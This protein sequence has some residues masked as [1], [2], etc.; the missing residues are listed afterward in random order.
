MSAPFD[1]T[2]CGACCIEAGEVEVTEDDS[3][4]RHLTRSV[5]GVMGFFS[6]D[7]LFGIRRMAKERCGSRCVVLRGTVGVAVRC[8]I[9]D[10]RPAV[11]RGFE[12]GSDG[13]LASR[14]AMANHRAHLDWKP[15][16]YDERP[17]DG[18]QP[19]KTPRWMSSVPAS[20]PS[21]S[22]DGE[23]SAGSPNPGRSCRPRAV[24][25]P[26]GAVPG[27]DPRAVRRDDVRRIERMGLLRRGLADAGAEHGG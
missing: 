9:Y 24:F 27:M 6:D 21:P 7:H 10:R 3:T 15:W 19:P 22:P 12:P 17:L 2:T 23:V 5:R 14:E 16:G 8:G 11:C 26:A 13:C 4:P 20:D 25:A 18:P 1:C